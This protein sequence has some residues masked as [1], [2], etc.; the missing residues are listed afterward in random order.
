MS[1]VL[2]E[3]KNIR[4]V[5]GENVILEDVSLSVEEGEVVVIIGPSGAGKSTFLRC[6]NR[7]E[8]PDSGQ[9]FFEGEEVRSKNV[10]DIRRKMGMVFQHFNLFPHLTVYQ[11]IVLGPKENMLISKINPVKAIKFE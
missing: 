4:K 9:V 2:L 7:L 3:A 5:F 11:N 1:K 10:V 8:K 6:L